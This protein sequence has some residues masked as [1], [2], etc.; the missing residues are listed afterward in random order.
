MSALM[1]IPFL[2][3]GGNLTASNVAE[4]DYPEWSN[5]TTYQRGDRVILTSTHKVYEGI[6]DDNTGNN[7]ATTVLEH[8]LEVGSTNRFRAFDAKLGQ[9]T[10]NAEEITYTIG[11]PSRLDA[12]ALIEMQAS[13]VRLILKNAGGAVTYDNTIDLLDTSQ[14]NDW[15]DFFTYEGSYDPEVVMS[16]L[17]AIAGGTMELTISNPGGTAQIAEIVAGKSEFLGELQDGTRSGFTDY[18][19]KEVDEFGNITIVKRPTARRAE[20]NLK[21]PTTSNR[22]IQRALE[23]ARGSLAFF[24]PGEDMVSYYV[25][26][27]GVADDFFPPLSSDGHTFATL[28]LTGVS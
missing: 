21:Y 6:N 16:D 13:S 5:A 23:D 20:W 4:N 18:S 28:S 8:W 24:Y 11:L 17:G 7:P 3:N 14:I 15:L 22:R 19:R 10:W 25:S 9:S 1:I 26:V 27:Y 2:V 12:V